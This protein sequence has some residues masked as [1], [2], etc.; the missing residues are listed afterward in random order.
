MADTSST[1]GAN[2]PKSDDG[3]IAI[4]ILVVTIIAVIG[5]FIVYLRKNKN[6][7]SFRDTFTQN[8]GSSSSQGFSEP[9]EK[10]NYLRAKDK[11]DLANPAQ[12]ESLKKLL[13]H[14]ALKVIPML[15]NLQNEGQ[16]VDRLYRKGMLTDD[17]HFK[18]KELKA[19]VDSEVQEVQEEAALLVKGWEAHIWPQAMTF[20]NV[21][22][23]FAL[24]RQSI[25]P[26]IDGLLIVSIRI[27][28][29]SFT[30][31][32][33]YLLFS[34]F[35]LLKRDLLQMIQKQFEDRD[36]EAQKAVDE[37]KKKQT[38][39]APSSSSSSSAG[40]SASSSSS[41]ASSSGAGGNEKKKD[42]KPRKQLKDLAPKNALDEEVPASEQASSASSSGAVSGMVKDP[43][44]IKALEAEKMA[45]Q[46]L[47]VVG[48]IP[49]CSL[50]YL[51]FC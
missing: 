11:C 9:P 49:L 25:S 38:P 14:R 46:L 13:M 6:R 42:S 51:N 36:A 2:T 22:I 12:V 39:A 3:H 41:G 29:R 5:G 7:A 26:V 18:M 15:L 21:S 4:V 50:F 24:T 17:M 37:K 27:L 19:F 23:P 31:F 8:N 44:A 28:I 35:P 47:E 32:V 16:S 33:W 45:R 30:L 1:A 34:I 40:A 20:H 48:F 10:E 43:E